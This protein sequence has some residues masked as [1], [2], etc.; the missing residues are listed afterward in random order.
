MKEKD[1]PTLEILGQALQIETDGYTFYQLIAERTT[2]PS[3]REVFEKL[4][5]DEI[6]HQGFLRDVVSRYSQA[7][8]A[9]FD[10]EQ[11]RQEWKAF[12]DRV[13]GERFRAEARGATFEISALSIGMQLESR[14]IAAYEK[15]AAEAAA[16]TVR[17]FYRFL[18][19]WEKEH[20]EGL[21]RLYDSV[22]TDQWTQAGFE[23]F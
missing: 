8:T 2:K 7:G 11:R 5:Q 10:I 13:F 14:A 12:S 16:S 9:A 17:D 4:A 6:A 23:P 20:L 15:A 3:V 21:R 19:D 22:R 1:Q 18:G